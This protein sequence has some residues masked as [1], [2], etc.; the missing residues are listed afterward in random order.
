MASLRHDLSLHRERGE[1]PHFL[2]GSSSLM[3]TFSAACAI[4]SA[5]FSAHLVKPPM[6]LP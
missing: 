5:V 4:L 3:P 2:G 6:N 1:R